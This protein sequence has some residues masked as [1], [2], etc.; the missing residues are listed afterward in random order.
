MSEPLW[1]LD[2]LVAATGGRVR[3]MPSAA[4]SGVSI[5]SRSLQPGEAFF[6]I[7]NKLDGHAFVADALKAGAE[8]AVVTEKKLA[9]MPKDAP[10]A[11]P[12]RR[13]RCGSRFPAKGRPSPRPPPTTIIGACR[14]RSRA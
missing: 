11:R 5:D 7:K 2:A 13:T 4:I 8:L 9:E 6:A 14:C 12:A 3:G 1:T 10:P